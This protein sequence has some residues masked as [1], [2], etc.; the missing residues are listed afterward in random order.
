MATT[1]GDECLG[2]PG[3]DDCESSRS[4]QRHLPERLD[5]PDD[6]AEQPDE[7]SHASDGAEDPEPLLEEKD[8]LRPRDFEGLGD[9]LRRSLAEQE[10]FAEDAAGGG[11]HSLAGDA[12]GG[13]VVVLEVADDARRQ[14][15]RSAHGSPVVP[16][17]LQKDGHGDDRA[18]PER[19]EGKTPVDQNV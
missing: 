8:L 7:G 19:V 1:R 11:A 2:Y 4:G 13:K 15:L 17:P 18:D 14:L 9:P 16:E 10:R 6:G 3:R 5:D 12:G